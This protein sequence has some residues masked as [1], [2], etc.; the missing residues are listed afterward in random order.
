MFV[1]RATFALTN[2]YTSNDQVFGP[3]LVISYYYKKKDDDTCTIHCLQ[4]SSQSDT[5]LTPC[6][7]H[8]ILSESIIRG[9]KG[10]AMNHAITYRTSQINYNIP[11]LTPFT[12][13]TSYLVE[14]LS[15]SNS[16]AALIN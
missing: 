16:P 12:N 4:M 3:T 5:D 14:A 15:T 10:L 11:G 6:C 13:D 1:H 9:N 7:S 2:L 8:Y